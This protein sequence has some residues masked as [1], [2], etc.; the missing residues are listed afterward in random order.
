MITGWDWLFAVVYLVFFMGVIMMRIGY[1]LMSS[2]DSHYPFDL[3][4]LNRWNREK[5][6]HRAGI[7]PLP[8]GPVENE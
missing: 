7:T 8:L 1:G 5:R 2:R 3:T 6:L 4:E